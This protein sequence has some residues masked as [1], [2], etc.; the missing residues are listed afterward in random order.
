MSR[1]K[2]GSF[3]A[4]VDFTDAD[5]LDRLSDAKI[6]LD[7]KLKAVPKVG[8]SGDIV[9]AQCD[10]F[11]TFFNV[12]FYDG[13]GEEIFEGRHSLK[14]CIEAAESIRAY[15]TAEKQHIEQSYGKYQVQ[16]HGNREQRRQQQKQYNKHNYR[17]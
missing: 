14:L 17:K 12:L 9:R 16:S 11:Y 2:F 8:K 10:C 15:E 1:W 3:E 4:E 13:A 5:F 6:A 7:V